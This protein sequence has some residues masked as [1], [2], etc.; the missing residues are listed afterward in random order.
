MTIYI[1][2]YSC[3]NSLKHLDLERKEIAYYYYYYYYH[4]Y[5]CPTNR[6]KT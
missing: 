2:I 3:E 6:E 4:C 1:Y 5:Y